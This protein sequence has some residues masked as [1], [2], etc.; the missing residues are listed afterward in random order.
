[1]AT[2]TVKQSALV[3]N[4]FMAK[5]QN[6]LVAADVVTWKEHDAEMDDRNGMQV[7]EQVGPKYK[8][9]QT[10]NGVKDLSSGVDDSVFGSEIFKITETFNANMGWGDF[11]KIRDVGEARESEALMGAAADMANA[12]DAY[13]LGVAVK[14][15]NSW[16]G[17]LGN[18]IDDTDEVVTA[19]TRLREQGVP[20]SDLRAVMNF[21][22]RQGLGDQ[23][24]NLAG[25]GEEAGKALRTGFSGNVGGVPTLFTQQLPSLTMGSRAGTILV[26]GASQNVNYKDVATSAA[27]GQYM[28]QTIA[29]DG[30]TGATDTIKAGEV[31]TIAGVYA[32]DNRKQA[33]LDYLQ[34]FTVVSD[35][36]AATNAVA[37]LRIFPAII[38]AGSG[39]GGDVNVNT[40]H[41]TVSAAPA[42]N[43]AITFLGT[44]S[45]AYTPRAIIQKQAVVV[46]TAPL[47]LPATGTAMRRKL[48]KVPLSVRMWQHSDFATGAHSIRFDCALTANVRDRM[49]VCRFN[50]S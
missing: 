3:L 35:A 25:P 50:G 46:D 16:V 43:A 18:N 32:Y 45:T 22:D 20:D 17:T 10:S 4:T 27:P 34:Q 15:S 7:I 12:I 14:C 39:S 13:V 11:V 33:A 2:V 47:I 5:L 29:I 41:A 26:N 1:M 48:Q 31:F 8:I 9:T 24:L 49:R 23:V 30:L 42:D 36:T 40:A 28:T 19:Y 6:E 38:V 37:A 21:K 44:A